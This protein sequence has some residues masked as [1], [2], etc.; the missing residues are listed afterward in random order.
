MK[1]CILGASGFI[2]SSLAGGLSH[3]GHEVTAV[4]RVAQPE[5]ERGG[6]RRL[7]TTM[8]KRAIGKVLVTCRPNAV[9]H[10]VGSPTIDYAQQ[11]PHQD[12]SVTVAL[13]SEVLEAF[14]KSAQKSL[15]VLVSSAAIYGDRGSGFLSESLPPKPVSVYGYNKYLAELLVDQYR[16]RY[17]LNTLIIRPFSIYGEE[18]RKQVIFD[19]CQKFRSRPD[20]LSVYGTGKELR[21]F[22]YINDFVS[23]VSE[24]LN[25]ETTGVF[26]IASGVPTALADLASM[27]GGELSPATRVV[28]TGHV[29]RDNPSEL[30]ADVSK[31][32][33]LGLRHKIPIEI[34][35]SRVCAAVRR[36]WCLG[37]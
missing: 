10:C 1:I 31:I 35:I 12:F 24:L 13:L 27:I 26:N 19:L 6:I 17:G 37:V 33:N 32:G 7:S 16:R 36:A 9:V 30:V 5:T 28:F 11:N 14:R 21:D 15:F 4:S 34:G 29:S 25:L 18:L 23:H 2:G 8:T 22:L 3:L 20:E